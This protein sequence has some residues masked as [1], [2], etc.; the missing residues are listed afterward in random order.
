MSLGWETNTP[1]YLILYYTK[2]GKS[3][4]VGPAKHLRQLALPLYSENSYNNWKNLSEKCTVISCYILGGETRKMAQS[5]IVVKYLWGL[6]RR[7]PHGI[8]IA[9]EIKGF[10]SC[11]LSCL[12]QR[13]MALLSHLRRKS[14]PPLFKFCPQILWC[15]T[16]F[17]SNDY[18]I[19]VRWCGS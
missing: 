19:C 6:L 9:Q 1:G 16:S 3:K 7:V 13:W 10:L 5:Q 11:G 18:L 8:I 15:L 17:I 4:E 12:V 14:K 2:R